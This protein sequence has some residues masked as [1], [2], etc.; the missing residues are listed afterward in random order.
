M[1]VYRS[2]GDA[3]GDYAGDLAKKKKNFSQNNSFISPAAD[4]VINQQGRR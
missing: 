4:E 3:L 1:Q 2:A